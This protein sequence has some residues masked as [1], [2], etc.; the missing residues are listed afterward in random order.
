MAGDVVVLDE[1]FLHQR[2]HIADFLEFGLVFHNGRVFLHLLAQFHH[3]VAQR[4][5]GAP[6]HSQLQLVGADHGIGEHFQ[7]EVDFVN[8]FKQARILKFLVAGHNAPG[9]VGNIHGHAGFEIPHTAHVG[10]NGVIAYVVG[11]QAGDGDNCRYH[12]D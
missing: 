3:L 7:F 8:H 5:H 6:G 4:I 9:L 12:Q 1:H 10:D 11:K 2:R